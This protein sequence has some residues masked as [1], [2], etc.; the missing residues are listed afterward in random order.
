MGG[1]GER[2]G[3]KVQRI[4]SVI[5]RYKIGEVNNSIENGEAKELICTTHGQ[6][7]EC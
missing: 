3:E 4:R 7:G 2:M 5:G 6:G 1:G